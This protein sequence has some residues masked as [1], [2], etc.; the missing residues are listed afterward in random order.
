MARQTFH[1]QISA[2]AGTLSTDVLIKSQVDAA[3]AGALARANHTGQQTMSTI[4][5][6]QTYV[7]G[8]VQLVVDAA[9]GAL[10]TLNELAAALGDDPNY[11]ATV[12]TSLNS[13]D[14]RIDV[15]EAAT[16][17]NTFKQNVGD[18]TASTFTLTHNLATLDVTV[19]VMQ[20]SNGQTVYPVITRPSTNTVLIDFGT[21]VPAS[22]AMRVFVRKA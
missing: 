12:T 9:P 5:D 2:Q 21:F 3:V 13:L 22:N 20:L 17:A 1:S 19:E 7:D 6:A 4:S 8:R 18:A 16:G 15:L 14:T 10:D 11:A